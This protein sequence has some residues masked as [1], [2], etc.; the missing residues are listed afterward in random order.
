M[1]ARRDGLER[2]RKQ[3]QSSALLLLVSSSVGAL[4]IGGGTRPAMAAC[5]NTVG[6]GASPSYTNPT[7]TAIPCVLFQGATISGNVVNA[8]TIS[9][10]GND[11]MQF[12]N[13]GGSATT[14][15]G[16]VS[17][18]GSISVSTGVGIV[19]GPGAAT[20]LGGITNS[21]TISTT[22]SVAD[23]G[24]FVEGQATF[25]G[26]VTNAGVI[27]AA[28]NGI[29]VVQTS[30]FS[31]GIT[32]AGAG[33]ITTANT[34]IFIEGAATGLTFNGNIS[35]AGTITAHKGIV[36]NGTTS[37]AL[38]H[39]K[40]LSGAVINSGTIAAA[41]TGITVN[42]ASTFTG[43]VTN[44]GTVTATAGVGILVNGRFGAV[45]A[46]PGA[47]PA[48]STY[49]GGIVST[50]TIQAGTI[51][52]QLTQVSN[53]SGGIISGSI[54]AA[55]TA[56]SLTQMSV[57]SG[58]IT[59]SGTIEG[60]NGVL[61]DTHTVLTIN[62][63]IVNNG[64]IVAT[65]GNGIGLNPTA[66]ANAAFNGNVTN[67][68][69][70]TATGGTAI[71]IHA[72][73]NNGGL[74]NNGVLSSSN[75]F[76]FAAIG[77]NFG[78]SSLGIVNASTATINGGG[79]AA[80]FLD[81]GTFTG[82]F[83]NNGA[84]TAANGDGVLATSV[85]VSTYSGGFTNSGTITAKTG[86]NV[87]AQTFNGLIVNSGN[88]TGTGGT[89]IEIG[90]GTN[91]VTF[92]QE[93]GTITGALILTSGV[94]GD[95]LNVAGG[96]VNG[97]I[98]DTNGTGTLNFNLGSG[99]FTYGSGF[100][101]SGMTSVNVNSGTVI[102]DGAGD[103]GA[104][105]LVSVAAGGALQIGDASNA[106]A[107][108]TG[109]VDVSGTL[110]GH[111]TITGPVAIVSGGTLA[112]GG[113]I[114]TLSVVGSVSVASGSFYD[115]AINDTAASQTAVTG[116]PGTFT[117]AGGGTGG[118]VVVTPQ[119]STLGPHGGTSFVIVSTTG[120][121]SGRF[122][123][124]T[125][126]NFTGSLALDYS[127]PDEII[128]DVGTGFEVLTTP[129]GAN[130]NQ[131]NVINGINNFIVAGS[132]PPAN[133][134]TLA[135]LSGQ[136]Y[137]NAL[138]QLDGEDATG[139]EKGAFQLMT[140]FLNLLLDPSQSGAGGSTGSPAPGF[141]EED[142]G[143]LP[144]DV[145]LA[146]AHALRQKDQQS[147]PRDFDQ[148]WS[149][150]GA[151]YGGSGSYSGNAVIGSSNVTASD[152]GYAAG[153]TYHLTP[154]TSYGFAVAGGGTNWSLSQALGTGR[155][156][157]FQAGVYG[158]T[159]FGAAYM[160][161]ALAFANHWFTTNRFAMGDDLTAHFMGQS[162][163]AR[164]EVGYRYGLPV[165]GY[166]AGVTPYAAVQVQ[167]FHTPGYSETDASGGGFGLNYAAVNATDTR[168]ELGSRFDDL[169]MLDGMPLLLRGRLA[170]AHDWVSN[171]AV[172]AV[173][174]TLPGSNFIVTGAAVPSNSALTT[175]AAE[176][177]I[178]ANWTATAK[179]DGEFASH[180]QTYAGTGV[181]KYSW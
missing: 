87:S 123:S 152:Y 124:V 100:H 176:L 103:G 171:P 49:S 36:A 125:E 43:G 71:L 107:S 170:W 138:T 169:T 95:V 42:G 70:V 142:Q 178:N 116:A 85:G 18:A 147:Q 164:G 159:H 12:S 131:Q 105:T 39:F 155:S 145:A 51:G 106:G 33:K 19:V 56:I 57:F 108:L 53:F 28:G 161:A 82:G 59:T 177:H 79:L 128:L 67:N 3:V 99:A 73:F 130:Q 5:A 115:V 4:L 141:A 44:T 174:Q 146:Y 118:A 97:N 84:I 21:G 148:R 14:V 134:Q 52:I 6:P 143:S 133:F 166:I 86:V 113:S 114:G 172:S 9:G 162:Y 13:S 40:N 175:A 24:M 32:N 120:G 121:V 78:S 165:S 75:K 89:A 2:R 127:N 122:A 92:D 17:N 62:G 72:D 83:T 27:N 68:G 144:P 160:Q 126:N 58:G 31:G 110:S 65:A 173:F 96:V 11:G 102:L 91:P 168:S 81:V 69:T 15:Q 77:T 8:G 137:L 46:A 151:G 76:G 66:A 139:A 158:T 140:Q 20:L 7:G 179:F 111:G 94:A 45:T 163:A 74:V 90:G 88:I 80:I 93:D 22:G 149:A 48:G 30:V 132:T 156:D 64:T 26:G 37:G 157:A 1:M 119:F 61:I 60:T 180:A 38:F 98:S 150:W 136:T 117:I 129:S 167:D 50:G 47:N 181:L 109:T 153:M 16:A 101:F 55:A 25:A 35:N 104:G 135:G 54:T 34:G 41:D 112:P 154:Q 29:D 23:H 63:D 10:A